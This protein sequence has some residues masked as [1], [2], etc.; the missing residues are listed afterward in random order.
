MTF[1]NFNNLFSFGFYFLFTIMVIT[2]TYLVLWYLFEWKALWIL[3]WVIGMIH[4]YLSISK[5]LLVR[6][7][8]SPWYTIAD[9]EGYNS[10]NNT[11]HIGELISFHL[12]RSNKSKVENVKRNCSFL[13]NLCMN[14]SKL[15]TEFSS[16]LISS[17]FF[18]RENHYQQA[19][20]SDAMDVF[21]L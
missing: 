3:S 10:I 1:T 2:I 13:M 19:I 7:Q 15:W 9:I 12:A 14:T 16:F 11:R 8:G 21:Q 6:T 4:C 5:I 18:V 17:F 20:F